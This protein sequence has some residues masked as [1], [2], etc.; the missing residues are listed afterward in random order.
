[1]Q[2][3]GQG[4]PDISASPRIHLQRAPRPHRREIPLFLTSSL[5]AAVEKSREGLS[6]GF[7]LREPA[8]GIETLEDQLTEL[9]DL[10][11]LPGLLDQAIG[12][13][14][15]D[16]RR[17]YRAFWDQA[18][19]VAA[20]FRTTY[21]SRVDRER[22]W[23]EYSDLCRQVKELGRAERED[24]E[25]KSAI[26]SEH[27]L[28]LV[29]E[30]GLWARG[31]ETTLDLSEARERL[32]KAMDILKTATFIHEDRQK[33]FTAWREAADQ[34]STRRQEIHGGNFESLER[35]LHEAALEVSDSNTFEAAGLLR[36]LKTDIQ[37]AEVSGEQRRVLREELRALWKTLIDRIEAR[38]AE[39]TRR[40][41]EREHQRDAWRERQSR[42]LDDLAGWR[43]ENERR[44]G[45]LEGEAAE[46]E[47]QI[48]TAWNDSWAER[49]QGWVQ[50]KYARIRDLE[51]RNEELDRQMAEIRSRLG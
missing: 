13:I 22:L 43:A 29:R 41:E 39:Q 20:H 30:A 34:V 40:R 47:T 7:G 19:D 46:L 31:G 6:V 36:G 33:C 45:Q 49:A 44:I 25:A 23:G 50:A 32:T 35:D 27:V 26:N 4:C 42:R 2:A 14:L 5:A 17:D 1:M 37:S 15:P 24:Q 18:R 21:L 12:V 9:R 48:A 8:T 28:A 3:V 11:A 51:A 10:A 38:K 16:R